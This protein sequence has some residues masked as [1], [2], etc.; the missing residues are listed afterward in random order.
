M[1]SHPSSTVILIAF[2]SAFFAA[3]FDVKK[4]CWCALLQKLW[5]FYDPRFK[6]IFRNLRVN[7]FERVVGPTK[8]YRD[9]KIVE[10]NVL[11]PFTIQFIT[12]FGHNYEISSIPFN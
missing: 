1:Q 4:S 2:Y 9:I 3:S 10:N 5:P 12:A 7:Q 11:S 6:K 8:D